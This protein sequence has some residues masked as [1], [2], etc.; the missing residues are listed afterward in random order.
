MITALANHSLSLSLVLRPLAAL[1]WAVGVL[2]DHGV[3]Q[4]QPLSLSLVLRPLATLLWP[5]GVLAT[6]ARS[7]GKCYNKNYS[8]AKVGVFSLPQN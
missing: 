5:V 7:R 1:L 6:V 4:S 2:H 3:G 8:T